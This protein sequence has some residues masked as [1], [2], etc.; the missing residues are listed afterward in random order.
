M[1]TGDN[2]NT[3]I[4]IAKEAG[5]L[6]SNYAKPKHGEE[7]GDIRGQYIVMEGKT[8]RTLIE[9]VVPVEEP[10]SKRGSIFHKAPEGE[11]GEEEGH[12]KDP[13]IHKERIK[14]MD[15]FR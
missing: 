10:K 1:V 13:H 9:G 6:P 15:K 12:K 4:A 2:I 8:F 14:N 11:E 5:I 7:E 3:A